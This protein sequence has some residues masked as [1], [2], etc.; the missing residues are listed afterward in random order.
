MTLARAS[1]TG[2]ALL[3]SLACGGTAA[4]A[5]SVM[6]PFGFGAAQP[7]NPLPHSGI[8]G[9]HNPS[10]FLTPGGEGIAAWDSYCS[11]S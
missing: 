2:A 10:L 4:V 7:L 1:L 8:A 11:V 3:L 5:Q 9:D 6:F